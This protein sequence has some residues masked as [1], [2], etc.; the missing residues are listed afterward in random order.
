ME[1]ILQMKLNMLKM[2]DLDAF[3]IGEALISYGIEHVDCNAYQWNCEGGVIVYINLLPEFLF[4]FNDHVEENTMTMWV[5]CQV[6]CK[7]EDLDV[8]VLKFKELFSALPY[9]PFKDEDAYY[10][11][12]SR[13]KTDVD[14]FT[15]I[16]FFLNPDY[17]SGWWE[18]HTLFGR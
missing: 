1:E 13:P 16:A 4:Y 14:G 3:K 17:P 10:G 8:T 2:W 9:K 11:Y 5:K 12:F 7:Q 18:N 6:Q 15:K